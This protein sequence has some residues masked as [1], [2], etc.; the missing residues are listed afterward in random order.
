MEFEANVFKRGVILVAED[1]AFVRQMMTMALR[2]HGYRVLTAIDGEDALKLLR[3]H[4]RQIDLALID[5]LMPKVSGEKVISEINSSYPWVPIIAMS[6]SKPTESMQTFELTANRAFVNKPYPLEII[7]RL[8]RSMLKAD[9]M[10][11]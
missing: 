3:R 7:L 4:K 6:G 2:L 5:I 10:A 8:V 1:D 9:P 11:H